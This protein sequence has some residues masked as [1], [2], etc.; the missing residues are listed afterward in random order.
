MWLFY[1]NAHNFSALITFF[2]YGISV[3]FVSIAYSVP[4]FKLSYNALGEMIVS[5]VLTF[6]APLLGCLIQ[7]GVIS[8]NLLFSLLPLFLNNMSRMI[9]MNIPDRDGDLKGGKITSVV[10][11][12]EDKSVA[13]NNLFYLINYVYIIPNLPIHEYVKLAYLSILPYRWW[14]SLRINR[15]NWW[16]EQYYYDSIPFHESLTVAFTGIALCIGLYCQTIAETS[17]KN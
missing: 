14:Q 13:L 2:L 8:R 3:L 17:L 7:N 1:N 16:N 15:P 9:V 6:A 12:G 11:V 10:L 4:P 5:Y